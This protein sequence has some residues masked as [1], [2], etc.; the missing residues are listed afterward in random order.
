MGGTCS[1]NGR[2]NKWVCFG[3]KTSK[4]EIIGRPR[5]ILEWNFGK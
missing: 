2:C 4:E 1:T 5:I 3:S